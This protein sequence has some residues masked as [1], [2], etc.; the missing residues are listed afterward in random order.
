MCRHPDPDSLVKVRSWV[1]LC[2]VGIIVLIGTDVARGQLQ[3]GAPW[4]M[5]GM[6]SLRVGRS[7]YGLT[8]DTSLWSYST[9][10]G[11][12]SSP[13][14]D[15]DGTVFIGSIDSKVYALNGLASVLRWSYSTGGGI[16][17]SPAIGTDGTVYIGSSDK[18]VYAL[19]GL[20]GTQRWNFSTGG[21]VASS[22][23]I[24]TDGTIYIGSTDYKVYAL[25]GLTGRYAG[26]T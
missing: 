12:T 8:T 14:I 2:N 4:P 25:S 9:G 7:A 20:T 24:G 19:S 18:R 17:S 23:A 1:A 10:G 16:T 3:T 6:N 26:V 11:V 22:P 21:S 13:A 15:V 5:H